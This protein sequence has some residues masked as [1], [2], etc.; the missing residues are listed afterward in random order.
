MLAERKPMVRIGNSMKP[1][2]VLKATSSPMVSRSFMTCQPPNQTMASVP[3][4][5]KRKTK[6]K[7][8]AKTRVVMRFFSS[9]S[10]LTAL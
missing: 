9:S 2:R 3:R 7:L 5:A 10:S 4:L 1:S 8:L 6:G